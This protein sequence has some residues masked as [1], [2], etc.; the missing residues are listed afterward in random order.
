MRHDLKWFIKE[1]KRI[2]VNVLLKERANAEE[3]SDMNDDDSLDR[4]LQ[5]FLSENVFSS[6]TSLHSGCTTDQDK[7]K[8]EEQV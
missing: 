3:I 6:M 5:S 1:V 2:C 4:E 7:I 8:V